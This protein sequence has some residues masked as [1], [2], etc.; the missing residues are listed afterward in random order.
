MKRSSL[1]EAAAVLGRR[2]LRGLVGVGLLAIGL[3][4]GGCAGNNVGT[5][6]PNSAKRLVVKSPFPT[7]AA[8][9]KLTSGAP[10]AIPAR[11]VAT[12]QQWTVDIDAKDS[13]N[14]KSLE[15]NLALLTGASADDFAFTPELRCSARELARFR[16]EHG[17]TPD[18]RLDR[19]ILAACGLTANV[20]AFHSSAH[21]PANVKDDEIWKAWK[22]KLKL[23]RQ[24]KGKSAGAWMV[25]KGDKV[26]IAVAYSEPSPIRMTPADEAGKV[27]VFGTVPPSAKRVVGFI[28][29]GAHGVA[30]CDHDASVALPEIRMV[31]P[32][33][34]SDP[35]AWVQV[36]THPEGHQLMHTVSLSIARRDDKPITLTK[37]GN[38]A[39]LPADTSAAILE[40]VNRT[41]AQAS[42]A[43]LEVAAKQA[44]VN[45]KVAPH[46][47]GA[48]QANDVT[49]ADDLA[50]GM[51]AGW[52]VEGGTIR[53]GTFFS[54]LMSGT[55]DPA[56][57]LALSLEM[58]MGRR[59]LLAPDARKIAI[60]AAALEG[61]P[62]IGAV[63]TTYAMF[64]DYAATDAD[65]E[66][67]RA[68]G[69]I[70][71]E[72]A[73]HGLGPVTSLGPMPEVATLAKLVRENKREGGEALESALMFESRRIHR[74]VRG[75]ALVTHDLDEIVVPTELLVPS[76]VPPQVGVEVTHFKPEGSPWGAYLLY[77]ITPADGL[78]RRAQ[79]VASAM[80]TSSYD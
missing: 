28:N 15:K 65:R 52:D 34:D 51:L 50:L 74:G 56:S 2:P 49:V 80:S 29:Q 31:C 70:D 63:V 37:P 62:S 35:W 11:E 8:I 9:E 16:S 40:G 79:Q 38:L 33:A 5:A 76:P 3:V 23:P 68:F 6:A 55:K 71:E 66:R 32:M 10:K 30:E 1:L 64:G 25:R 77:V 18:E 72:R 26:T 27:I 60:G 46:F 44:E 78:A 58:P 21:V 41:R 48:E 43:P 36:M 17:A 53:D 13:K 57:W 69:R 73:K 14:D 59:S 45:T 24:A 4:I 67:A 19:F 61:G 12:A 22:G 7:K 54:G 39:D 75:W 47:F 20:H 42:L